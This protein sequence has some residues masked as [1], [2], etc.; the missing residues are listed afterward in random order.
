MSLISPS[1]CSGI[2][3]ERLRGFAATRSAGAGRRVSWSAGADRRV[4]WS[5]GADRR[6]SWSAGA[7]RRVSWCAGADR[8]VSWSAGDASVV[9]GGDVGDVGVS[10]ISF[11][12]SIVSRRSSS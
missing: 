10:P 7:D 1:S 3:R 2:L 6:V 12:S 5:A 8:R 9:G 4:S 11:S